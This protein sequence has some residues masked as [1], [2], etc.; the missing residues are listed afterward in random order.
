MSKRLVII[1]VL[2]I[3]LIG[4]VYWYVSRPPA[5]PPRPPARPRGLERRQ[6]PKPLTPIEPPERKPEIVPPPAAVEPPAPKGKPAQAPPEAPAPKEAVPPQVSPEAPVA[7][8]Q[9][10]KPAESPR[11]TPPPEETRP[12]P[13]PPAPEPVAKAIVPETQ[14]RPY[15][16]Q[17][18]S[19]VV[20]Q[21]AIALKARLEKL[22][23]GTTIQKVIAR[24]TRHRV[25]AGE[26]RDRDEADQLARRLRA[27][28]FSPKLV[29]GEHGQ[30]AVEVGI[31]FQ[32]NDAIDLAHRLQQKDYVPKIVTQTA[33][34]PVYAVR[35][36]AYAKK[37]EALQDVKALKRKG[38]A[39]IIV[40]RC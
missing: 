23:Y 11:E 22:G 20:K 33:P 34:T 15:S 12:A 36:G 21:N 29:A 39:P 24:I 1:G 38:F 17:V 27:D 40:R 3:V 31:S 37:S 25:S 14:D 7:P 26:F 8:P 35:V 28:G 18:A 19:L 16:V 4:A 2:G 5:S 30:F 13:E 9:I 10:A 32:Q 6:P